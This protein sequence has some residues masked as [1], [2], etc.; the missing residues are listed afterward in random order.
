MYRLAAITLTCTLLALPATPP[1]YAGAGAAPGATAPEPGPVR[2]IMPTCADEVV[3]P[4][5]VTDRHSVSTAAWECGPHVYA[6][7]TTAAGTWTRPVDLAVARQPVAATDRRG[8][9]TVAYRMLH[10]MGIVTRR[11]ANGRWQRPVEV[12]QPSHADSVY[13][14]SHQIAVNA[15]G[16]TL[17]A[18]MQKDGQADGDSYPIYKVAAFRPYDG[19][20]GPTVRVGDRGWLDATLVDGTGHASILTATIDYEVYRR[21]PANQWVAHS[22][23]SIDGDFAGAAGNAAG[24][25]LVTTFVLWAPTNSVLANEKPSAKPWLPGV[26]VGAR[27]PRAHQAP[28]VL[29]SAG[30]GA[31]AFVSDTGPVAV[32]TRPADGA[33]SPGVPVSPSG[34]RVHVIRLASRPG[35]ALAVSWLDGKPGTE[36]LWL[37]VRPAAGT[38][39]EPVQVT[40]SSWTAVHDPQLSFRPNGDLIAAW[41]GLLAGHDGI[42]LVSRVLPTPPPPR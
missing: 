37:A 16:D 40:G 31:V 6:A 17:V 8:R 41:S 14:Q 32:A 38:W 42:R 33:W 15:R 23:A 11:W 29:D 3:S 20:W 35:G 1:T 27:Y 7:R 13:V 12:T 4:Q 28:A 2:V 25:M 19:S 39:S 30:R 5:L 10:G 36:Q 26:E 21:T 34:R 22:A 18:W 9:V 24:A